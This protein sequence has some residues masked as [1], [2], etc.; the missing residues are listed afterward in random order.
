MD[1]RPSLVAMLTG[2]EGAVLDSEVFW[3]LEIPIG[4]D[5]ELPCRFEMWIIFTD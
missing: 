2:L 5:E 3:V 1:K 4:S